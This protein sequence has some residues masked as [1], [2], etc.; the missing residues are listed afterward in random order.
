MCV[1]QEISTEQ[2]LETR[3]FTWW[4]ITGL[5]YKNIFFILFCIQR[6]TSDKLTAV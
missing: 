3:T 1:K 5:I 4:V 6:A 2:S